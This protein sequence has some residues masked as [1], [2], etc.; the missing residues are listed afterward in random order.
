MKTKTLA[1][2]NG[3][4]GLIG[5]I[6]LL[7]A[8]WFIL[9]VASS[10][11][12]VATGLMT[13]FVYLVKLALLVLGIVGAVYYKGDTPVRTAPSVL[14]S[15]FSYSFLRMDWRNLRNNRW[16]IVPSEPE[17]ISLIDEYEKIILRS[18]KWIYFGQCFSLWHSW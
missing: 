7:F 18:V 6:F 4:V 15:D 3:V 9:G 8:I 10:G 1:V 12:E 11:S 5:G 17:K 2:T 14:L 16:F 13:L